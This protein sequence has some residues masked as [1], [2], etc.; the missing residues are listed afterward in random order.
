M[1]R[2]TKWRCVAVSLVFF[3]A[4]APPAQG[5]VI[6]GAGPDL[7]RLYQ[8]PLFIEVIG[9]GGPQRLAEVNQF[10]EARAGDRL[11]ALATEQLAS[12]PDS[13]LALEILGVGQLMGGDN[14][15]A[16]ATLERAAGIDKQ[17]S[18]PTAKL[19]FALMEA[20]RLDDAEAALLA[21]LA[22]DPTDSFAHR[23]L[24]LLYDYTEQV[25]KAIH[26]LSRGLDGDSR[27]YLG[28]ALTLARQF[29]KR[30]LYTQASELME[31]RFPLNAQVVQ[32]HLTIAR[33]QVGLQK[34]EG[35]LARFERALELDPRLAPARLGR[36]VALRGTGNMDAAV[37]ALESLTDDPIVGNAAI[38]ELGLTLL[39]QG[40]DAEAERV[41]SRARKLGVDD[42]GLQETIAQHYLRG[43][44]FAD[45]RDR[46]QRLVN[47]K[48]GSPR[49]YDQ[50][51]EL[52]LAEGDLE[53]ALTV[54]TSGREKYPGNSRLAF[55]L[56]MTYAAGR[57]YD[58]AV[59]AFQDA[60]KLAPDNVQVL[61]NLSLAQTRM[62]DH[63][64]ALASAVALLELQ[65]DRVEAMQFA[66]L[67]H[68]RSGDGRGARQLYDQVVRAQPDNVLALNNLANLMAD[69]DEMEEAETLA[70][71]AAALAPQNAQV[72]DTLGTIQLKRGDAAAALTS[73]RRAANLSPSLGV[74]QYHL[75]LTYEA[76]RQTGQASSSY[77]R[78]IE[79]GEGSE[80]VDAARRRLAAL[81]N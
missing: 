61:R 59:S 80:W 9:R 52:L 3:T 42:E 68:E 21:A 70:S 37:A 69:A 56:A 55:R 48:L 1:M 4:L 13:A 67:T 76:L 25:D 20:N 17:H 49:V 45:A 46:Y 66:A 71:R 81:K 41:F 35:A 15:A 24:G 64:G 47:K 43:S 77:I 34:W 79:L 16:I 30:G 73:Y 26:H 10:I 2:C 60:R 19:G 74:V 39:S 58:D 44:Q 53:G 54:L 31:G 63:S 6:R 27:G 28:E 38:V 14:A 65:P 11:V 8:E 62:G 36:A 7:V 78:A 29:N 51:S 12:D 18:G 32:A 33:S 75:G 40:E 22:I 57:R 23:K 72:L 5:D 50:L